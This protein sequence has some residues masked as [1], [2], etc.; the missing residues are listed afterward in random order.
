MR[1]KPFEYYRPERLGE[2]KPLLEE[3][4]IKGKSYSYYSG[5]T[6]LLT[7]FRRGKNEVDALI[8]IKDLDDIREI[9]Q[10]D[11]RIVI[12]SCVSLNE[13]I[14]YGISKDALSGIADHTVRN[15]IT[16]GGNICGR[17]P[18]R[19][20]ILPLLAWDADFVIYNGE[21]LVIIKGKD[22]FDKRMKLEGDEILYKIIL[23]HRPIFEKSIRITESTMV[24]YPVIH[25]Y[26]AILDSQIFIGVSGFAPFPLYTFVSRDRLNLLSTDLEEWRKAARADERASKEYRVK[27]FDLA[28]R[29]FVE[30]ANESL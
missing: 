16:I 13:V 27:L 10:E 30:V 5:G 22:V 9:K 25:L 11:S 20:A 1:N 26:G 17:L 12:G 6:E 24:D 8:D 7:Q 14:E 18:Y 2:L 19:E 29:E 23:N 21:N 15:K 3:L 28:L 4:T